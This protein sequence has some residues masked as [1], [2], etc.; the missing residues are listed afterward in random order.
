MQF[1]GQ[2][3]DSG[4]WAS[5]GDMSDSGAPNL[6]ESRIGAS[7]ADYE[8]GVSRRLYGVLPQQGLGRDYQGWN[9][10][11]V[12]I[13]SALVCVR[14]ALPSQFVVASLGG[15]GSPAAL[16]SLGVLG[17]WVLARLQQ[18]RA[19]P[20]SPIVGMA[21]VFA[22]AVAISYVAAA[23]RPAAGEE[24]NLATLGLLILAGWMGLLLV[25]HDGTDDPRRLAVFMNRLAIAGALFGGFGL[26]Q[27]A[28]GQAWVDKLSIPG[29]HINQ[30]IYAISVREG[31]TRPAGTAIHP[32]EFGAVLCMLLPVAIGRGLGYFH[33]PGRPA[34]SLLVRWL[35]AMIIVA[36]ISMSVTRSA[37]VGLV[38][39]LVSMAP[40][41]SR[42]QRIAGLVALLV[43]A[44][45]IFLFVPGMTGS[46]F[47]LFTGINDDA[48]VA[49]R[50]DSFAE[51]QGYFL[52]SPWV[53]RGFGTFLPR[54]RILDNQYLGLLLE[55][56]VIGVLAL[57]A[58]IGTVLWV[59]A[60]TW[61]R[62]LDN[63]L[64]GAGLVSGIAVLVGAV[65]MALFDGF[66]FPMTASL[67]FLMMGA[68]GASY[69][70][71]RSEWEPTNSL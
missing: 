38:L 48:G 54:Y 25:A 66:S 26:V 20:S 70:L 6:S 53:G 15:L 43:I 61:Q 27:I 28:T 24:F 57:A 51:T 29:L 42:V 56:G 63:A 71:A 10:D 33:R 58:L 11:G 62:S 17:W 13:L 39:G 7:E 45:V 60:R 50:L 65:S 59:S 44:T 35:P 1:S 64:R 69:R 47:G 46:V 4:N 31:F 30:F 5:G 18:T 67:W 55:T 2:Q 40:A 16:L 52:S 12:S 19:A 32:I 14:L 34:A 23:V 9:P 21:I 3:S 68:A 36:A 37:L 22:T 41:L 49:S 8:N